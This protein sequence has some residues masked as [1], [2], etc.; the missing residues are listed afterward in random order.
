MS[1]TVLVAVSL[2]NLPFRYVEVG[3]RWIGIAQMENSGSSSA[4]E[5]PIM[6][7]WPLRYWVR[8][9]I[10]ERVD[11]RLWQPSLLWVNLGVALLAAACVY[12][13]LW[14]R[15]RHLGQPF[16]EESPPEAK[17]GRRT[18]KFLDIA[19]AFAILL[20][21]GGILAYEGF[22]ARQ[23]EQAVRQL[24][25]YGN[26]HTSCWLPE[27]M[28]QHVPRGVLRTFSR[29]RSVQ[30]FRANSDIIA[31]AASIPNLVSLRCYRPDFNGPELDPLLDN[32]HFR[33]LELS[34]HALTNED[35]ER[36]GKMRYMSELSLNYSNINGELLA[37]LDRLPLRAV[38][39]TGNPLVLS[40]LGKPKWSQSAESLDL[41]RPKNGVEDSIEIDGWPRLRSFAVTR[42]STQMNDSTLRI[43]LA[44]LPSLESVALDRNQR[45]DLELHNLPR[46]AEFSEN[47]GTLQR[48]LGADDLL[49]GH[50]WLT[51][52]KVSQTPSLKRFGCFA[53]DL[54]ELSIADAQ[55]LRS[56]AI[57]SYLVSS[58]GS[59]HLTS[60]I[61]EDTGTWLRHLGE[62][63]GPAKLDLTGLP[64]PDVDLSALV[65]NKRIRHL[66]L[67][68]CEISFEQIRQLEGMG[69]LEKL[70][71]RSC[72]LKQDELSW[73]L[74]AFPNLEALYVNGADLTEL[75]FSDMENLRMFQVNKL[76]QANVVRIVDLPYLEAQLHLDCSPEQ[77]E[78]RNA[79]SLT[80][81]AIDAPWPENAQVSGLRDL[82]W[83]AGGGRH[84]DDQLFDEILGCPELDQLT[85]AYTSVSRERL[86][87]LGVLDGLSMLA[88]PGSD[89][90][91]SITTSWSPLQSL[92]EIN[93]D[94]T[95][96]S[97]ATIAWL[98]GIDSL[99]RVSLNRVP[100]DDAAAD[101][102]GELQQVSEL[103]LS[104]V[105]V[106]CEKL[107]PLLDAGNIES[108]NLSGWKIDD[109]VID[110][111]CSC[112][113]LKLVRLHDTATTPEQV[114]QLM[115]ANDAI[116]ID[117]GKNA[118]PISAVV[119]QELEQRAIALLRDSSSG[120]RQAIRVRVGNYREN[121]SSGVI[122]WQAD[123][124]TWFQESNRID[125]D[126][127]RATSNASSAS[128]RS[129]QAP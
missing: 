87:E 32:I 10:D 83:F 79:R 112:P 43:R 123:A 41:S 5:L 54:Q 78:I 125:L 33:S 26:C 46:L 36:I 27:A 109:R 3:E 39:L 80:G 77:F 4:L 104:G 72:E 22:V 29:I 108:L 114:Q 42:I 91:D 24:S 128:L 23:H 97:V 21:P 47:V 28:V 35:A 92:W 57:G 58:I 53:G 20:V 126:R 45:H 113:S 106:E 120:W 56:F 115:E 76:R 68:G 119:Q 60:E 59:M 129:A 7:G 61:P 14:Y 40:R 111:L 31:K 90:D 101:A 70:D 25:R 38:D 37:Y 16:S 96:I 94:D 105:N 65:T 55:S 30:L 49:P 118:Q 19:I 69:Q 15:G 95:Q 71:V 9:D 62:L 50:M 64:M 110:A 44:N 73:I 81:I 99:R 34:H 103:Q 18:G 48:I 82:T 116:F 85:L 86:S 98:S 51:R 117:L 74:N 93:L 122:N 8:Y 121:G 107:T 84:V 17:R 75:D 66:S 52:I 2:A 1:A 63:S 12:G 124:D 102:L 11:D 100:F 89:I 13:F 67:S 6:A 127:F 88:L